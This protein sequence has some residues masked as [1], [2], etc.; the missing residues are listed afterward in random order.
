MDGLLEGVGDDGDG[1][2]GGGGGVGAGEC[3]ALDFGHAGLVHCAVGDGGSGASSDFYA[4]GS[5]LAIDSN[6]EYDCACD[7]ALDGGV[8][9]EAP[10][11]ACRALPVTGVRALG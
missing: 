4:C 5:A 11:A 3:V 8:G 2:F 9:R 6:S 10:S 1:G 7:G